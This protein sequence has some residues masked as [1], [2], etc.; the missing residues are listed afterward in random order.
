MQFAHSLAH[1]IYPR[2]TNNHRAKLLHTSSLLVLAIL[3]LTYQ[4]L[5]TITPSF[6]GLKILGYAANIPTDEVVR[7]TNQKR[8][9]AGV[10]QLQF[11]AQLSQAAR[12]KGEHMLANDYWAH[13][14]PDGTDPWKFFNDVGYKYRYAGENLARDF[15]NAQAAVDAW[16]ASPSHRDNLL[17]VRYKDIGIAVVEG[18]LNGVETTII[19]QLFGTPLGET[20]PEVPIAQAQAAAP[21]VAPSPVPTRQPAAPTP[22]VAVALVVTSTPTPTPTLTPMLVSAEEPMQTGVAGVL[23]SP[24]NTTRAVS[25]VTI[26]TLL[27]V[28]VVDAFVIHT[29]RIPRVG[30]RM[31][32]HIAFFGMLLIIV[33]IARA[34]S[35]L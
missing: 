28:M 6:T 17:S 33:V 25:L 9:E 24:F 32:A 26:V 12:A 23:I 4:L 21:T 29:R 34:G 5:L 31:F 16:M 2:Y 15:S 30:G 10:S 19:V 22:T 18:H 35:I 7:V 14:A 11:N 1:F 8:A 13:V 3:L 27:F 20:A